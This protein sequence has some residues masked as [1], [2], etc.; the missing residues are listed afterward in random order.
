MR[1]WWES[2][3]LLVRWEFLRMRNFMPLIIVVQ[4]LL[5]VGVVFGMA[6]LI[7]H[8]SP[9]SA[10]YLTTGA[11]TLTL[12]MMGLTFVPQQISQARLTGRH[13]YIASLPV[14]RLAPLVADVTFWLA[15]QIPGTV[16]TLIIGQLRF[17]IALRLSWTA[18]PAVALVALAGAS[19]GYALASVLK[20]QIAAEIS[21]FVS[22]A[23]LLFSPINF[24]ASRMPAVLRAVHAVLPVQYMADV[25]RGSLTGS[26]ADAAPLAFG[27]VAAWC[28]A[29]LA[30]SHWAATR[31]P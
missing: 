20:P 13:D 28:A 11:P 14:P 19:V 17:H 4:V 12:M 1:N 5:G 15:V 2:Y 25:V 3:R 24:P 31:R 30:L 27:V 16:V 10:L 18:I 22:I 29:G 26:Y 23:L 7:P 21:S 9:T 8:I 6:L